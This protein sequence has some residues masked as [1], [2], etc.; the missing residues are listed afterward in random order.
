MPLAT[1]FVEIFQN[2]KNWRGLDQFQSPIGRNLRYRTRANKGRGLYSKNV[3]WA[4]IAAINQ[5][6]LLF[7]NHF[8]HRIKDFTK[9]L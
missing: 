1:V 9:H 2:E 5:E 8:I 7:E 3:F 6:R 4:I